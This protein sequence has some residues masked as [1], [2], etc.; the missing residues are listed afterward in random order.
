MADRGSGVEDLHRSGL[1]NPARPPPARL[2]PQGTSVPHAA[3]RV[4]DLPKQDY[5]FCLLSD[6]DADG[7]G[8]IER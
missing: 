1:D 8:S 3:P 5:A 2:R 7:F 4:Y 6:G